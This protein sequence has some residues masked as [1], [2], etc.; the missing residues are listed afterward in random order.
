MID[1]TTKLRWRRIFRKRRH[2]VED[3][4]YQAEEQ[5]ERHFF[6]RLNRLVDV[7]RFIITWV[8]LF[9]L[10]IGGVIYQF[11]GLGHYYL[12]NQPVPGGTYTEGIIGSFTNANP[13]YATNSVDSAVSRLIFA[14]LLKYDSTNKLVGDLAESWTL[15]AAETTYTMKLRPNLTWQDGQPLTAKDVTY[16]YQTIQN[17]DAKSPL[18]PSWQGIAVSAPDDRT[19]VFKLPNTLSSFPFYLTNGIIPAHILSGIP[20]AQLRATRF[21]TVEPVGAGPFKW[22]A[23]EVSNQGHENR[24]EKVGLIPNERYY[25]GKPKLS[26]FVIH[27]FTDEKRMIASFE[28]RELTAMSGVDTL[29]DTFHS[30]ATVQQFSVP[31]TAQVMVFFKT[32]QEVLSDVKVRQALV[33]SVNQNELI[34]QLG[35]PVIASREPF[36]LGQPGYNP[37]IMQLPY[38]TTKA[39]QLL[40]EAGWVPGSDGIRTKN[41]KKLTFSLYSQSTSEYASVTHKLQ[42]DWQKLGVKVEVLLLPDSELQNTVAFHSYDALLY[43]I[44]LGPDPDIYAYWGSTQADQRAANRVN[45]SEYK[46]TTADKAL[47]GGRTRIDPSLRTLK[48]KPFLEAWRND[49]PALALYQPR[50]LYVT[51]DTVYGLNPTVMNAATDR[52]TNVANWMIHQAKA[53]KN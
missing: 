34:N 2:Q 53:R 25:A 43:G 5:I 22:S 21:N 15:D 51:R 31:L 38:D 28:N 8:L 36:L 13:I 33:E 41:G 42:S 39:A 3:L 37:A 35:F 7:R 40:T 24:E 32:S 16:T 18:Q 17:P 46:S 45:F 48:Y 12:E 9:V 47:E 11:T 26:K 30:D 6:K 23:V 19:V 44:S 20:A 4:G 50:Y 52:Y 1:R 14:G 27:A 29:P 10:L 49:A